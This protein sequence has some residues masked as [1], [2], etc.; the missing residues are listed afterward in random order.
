MAV[1][2]REHKFMQQTYNLNN[3]RAQ[4]KVTTFLC[5]RLSASW[6]VGFMQVRAELFLPMSLASAHISFREK[7]KKESQ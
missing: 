4:H 7:K 5:L 2:K 1:G 3:R 6:Q